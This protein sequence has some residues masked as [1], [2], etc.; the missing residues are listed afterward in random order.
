ME[1]PKTL[2]MSSR[3]HI[4]AG[5]VSSNDQERIKREDE[6]RSRSFTLIE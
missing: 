4:Q 1:H 5:Q 2:T 6:G 3:V